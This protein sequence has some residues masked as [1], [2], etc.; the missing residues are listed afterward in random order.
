[1]QCLLGDHTPEP[2][3]MLK[4]V[5]QNQ[6]DSSH[7]S[8]LSASIKDLPPSHHPL[9]RPSLPGV[10]EVDHTAG[11]KKPGRISLGTR[12]AGRTTGEQRPPAAD[13]H[14]YRV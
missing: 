10:C 1:M 11:P 14:C 12:S 9:T 7:R 2:S 8:D 4:P 5:I 3:E 13:T 6:T